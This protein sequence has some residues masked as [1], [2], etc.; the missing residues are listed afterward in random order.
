MPVTSSSFQVSLF[1]C[2]F[3]D[4]CWWP[5]YRA[6][7]DSVMFSRNSACP[8]PWHG[9]ACFH[10]VLHICLTDWYA[11]NS[12]RTCSPVQQSRKM[13]EYTLISS[14]VLIPVTTVNFFDAQYERT[15][16]I[17]SSKTILKPCVH[18][19][20]GTRYVVLITYW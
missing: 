13:C 10:G 7:L 5:H 9:S 11:Q 8:E 16:V 20:Y 19:M 6:V 15:H 17:L 1:L 3:C 12:V 4:C 14:S 2:K 18:V